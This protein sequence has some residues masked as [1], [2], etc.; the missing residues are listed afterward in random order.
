M[1]K[2]LENE[3]CCQK[4]S[5]CVDTGRLGRTSSS[6]LLSNLAT[7]RIAD[8]MISLGKHAKSTLRKV[9]VLGTR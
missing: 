5:S 3:G 7:L 1:S 6:E 4:R 8:P 9:A 2:V